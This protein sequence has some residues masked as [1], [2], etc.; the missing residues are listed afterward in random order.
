MSKL[1]NLTPV[2]KSSDLNALRQLYDEWEIQIRS[3]ESLGVVSETYGSLLCPILL[4]MIP[5]DIA[6]DY[7]RQRGVDDEWKVAEII[8][9]LQKEVQ[10]RERALQMTRSCNQQKEIKPWNK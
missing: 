8:S 6:L 4:Q 3:L 5:E 7:S 9:F 10:S 1:L 2:K